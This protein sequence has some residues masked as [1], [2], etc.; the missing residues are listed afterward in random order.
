MAS[1]IRTPLDTVMAY[2]AAYNYNGAD[3][4]GTWELMARAIPL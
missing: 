1:L 3:D 4:E 2:V